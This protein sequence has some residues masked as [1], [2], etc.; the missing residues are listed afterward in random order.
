MTGITNRRRYIGPLVA[1]CEGLVNIPNLIPLD[2]LICSELPANEL[3]SFSPT[4]NQM[5]FTPSTNQMEFTNN[6]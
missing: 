1:Q 6:G 4:D 2:Q 3:M 5:T